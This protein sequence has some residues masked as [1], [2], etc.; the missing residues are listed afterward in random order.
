MLFREKVGRILVQKEKAVASGSWNLPEACPGENPT[1]TATSRT[2]RNIILS[3]SP[4][5]KRNSSSFR[6]AAVPAQ[7][8]GIVREGQGEHDAFSNLAGD[9]PHDRKDLPTRTACLP[10]WKPPQP[11]SARNLPDSVRGKAIAQLRLFCVCFLCRKIPKQPS[12]V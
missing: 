11:V 5:C 4:L 10:S 7:G 8:P 3:F 12:V 6:T 9:V 2:A 1:Y